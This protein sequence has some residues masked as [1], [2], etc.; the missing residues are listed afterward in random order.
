MSGTS[1]AA[2]SRRG[3]VITATATGSSWNTR[4][5]ELAV[6]QTWFHSR[7]QAHFRHTAVLD[8]AEV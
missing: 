3:P 7:T 1:R 2:G 5:T 4:G 6:L 8:E